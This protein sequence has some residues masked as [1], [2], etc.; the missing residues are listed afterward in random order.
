MT[1]ELPPSVRNSAVPEVLRGDLGLGEHAIGQ[2]RM[3]YQVYLHRLLTALHTWTEDGASVRYE[4]P[5]PEILATRDARDDIVHRYIGGAVLNDG[6]V[7]FTQ[8][9][10]DH[11][12]SPGRW[13]IPAAH[14]GDD[15]AL[16]DGLI[17]AVSAGAGL[18]LTEV[19]SYL[20]YFDFIDRDGERARQHTVAVTVDHPEAVVLGDDYGTYRWEPATG[21]TSTV[22][23]SVQRLL[24]EL[25]PAPTRRSIDGG[26]QD[27]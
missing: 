27:A 4:L 5:D 20:G 2:V 19:R 10:T 17:R 15:E 13:E 6:W 18:S 8:R 14:L 26:A 22:D 7:L 11:E 25:G 1:D 16:I 24:N 3:L 9:R 23:E 12:I 21:L